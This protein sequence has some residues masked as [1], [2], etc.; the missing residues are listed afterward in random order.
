MA[1]RNIKIYVLE[2]VSNFFFWILI[3]RISCSSLLVGISGLLTLLG[4]M[5]VLI[6]KTSGLF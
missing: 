6:H 4:N 2:I 3:I 5:I 1:F